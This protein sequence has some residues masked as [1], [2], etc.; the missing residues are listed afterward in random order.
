MAAKHGQLRALEQ[1]LN[2]RNRISDLYHKLKA[3]QALATKQ[4]GEDLDRYDQVGLTF[5]SFA[6]YRGKGDDTKDPENSALQKAFDDWL[7]LLAPWFPSNELGSEMRT[8]KF[9][10]PVHG[11]S[12]SHIDWTEMSENIFR[13]DWH[14]EGEDPPQVTVD[15]TFSE[16]AGVTPRGW[17][18]LG[19]LCLLV[20]RWFF[21]LMKNIFLAI[22][23]APTPFKEV[24]WQS[25]EVITGNFLVL[26]D[27]RSGRSGRLSHIKGVNYFD[28]R[29]ELDP[30]VWTALPEHSVVALDHFDFNLDSRLH[31]LVRLQLL[32]RLVYRCR[33]RVVLV[34]AVDPVYYLSEGDLRS[35]ADS[36]QMAAELLERWTRVMSAFQ[37]V[38]F[39]DPGKAVFDELMERKDPRAQPLIQW[40]KE[41]CGHTIYLRAFGMHLFR[42]HHPA[43]PGHPLPPPFDPQKALEELV[44]DSESYYSV[45]WSTLS[46]REHLVLYQLAKDG[47]ANTKNDRA[48]RQLRRKGLLLCAPMLR[49]M[50]ESFRLFVLK[51]QDER[52][53]ADWERQGQQSSWRSVK[54]VITATTVGLAAWLFYAQQDLFQVSIGYVVTIGAAITAIAN[55]LSGMRGRAAAALKAS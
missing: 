22:G 37:K 26:G 16:W 30:H 4:I 6:N 21:L 13:L 27:P 53:I 32:E 40:I 48:I 51:A 49:I 19:L 54:I 5:L 8:L 34:S 17:M 46:A 28:L 38:N 52:E 15:S 41:E 39:A 31:N 2:R 43:G 50:N 9:D 7:A 33:C 23:Q 12:A 14:G 3:P 11:K 44:E 1:V 45:L 25:C 47:W 18:F 29:T 10:T 36:P 42:E 24:D 35:L 55:A 20:G